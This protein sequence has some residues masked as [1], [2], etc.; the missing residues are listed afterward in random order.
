MAL[1][2]GT[3]EAIFIKQLVQ[4]IGLTIDRPIKIYEDNQGCIAIAQNPINNKRTKHIDIKYHFSR[5]RILS[6]DILLSYIPTEIQQADVFTKTLP[7]KGFMR[8][9]QDIG[10]E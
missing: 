9:R 4:S 3:K 7:T 2:E 10:L 8:F 5:E 1:F 6:G